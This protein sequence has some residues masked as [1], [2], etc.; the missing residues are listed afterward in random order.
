MP[1]SLTLVDFITE[2]CCKSREYLLTLLV[3]GSEED[4]EKPRA[5][6]Q[7]YP[8]RRQGLGAG[9][10]QDA[11]RQQLPLPE[12][13]WIQHKPQ[14]YLLVGFPAP[15]SLKISIPSRER[16]AGMREQVWDKFPTAPMSLPRRWSRGM[17][18]KSSPHWGHGFGLL[19]SSPK[20]AIPKVLCGLS[21]QTYGKHL[22]GWE[23]GYIPRRLPGAAWEER[24]GR[25]C[26]GKL[27]VLLLG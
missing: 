16:F 24:A 3:S 6:R 4:G 10:G 7:W 12:F 23:V 15:E 1:E 18:G 22:Q 13:Q 5:A 14:H 25:R 21:Y 9:L 2:K 20:E 11:A 17:L 27:E 26:G 8:R 19:A